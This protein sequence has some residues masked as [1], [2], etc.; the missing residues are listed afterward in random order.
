LL[1]VSVLQSIET[2]IYEG[3]TKLK[4]ARLEIQLLL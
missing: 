2:P 3:L 4:R 1:G